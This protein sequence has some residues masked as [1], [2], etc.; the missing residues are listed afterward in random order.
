LTFSCLEIY[1]GVLLF[2]SVI[3]IKR[4]ERV[5][6]FLFF[7]YYLEEPWGCFLSPP[8]DAPRDADMELKLDVFFFLLSFFPPFLLLSGINYASFF[9]FTGRQAEVKP[10][11]R[12][13]LLF[14]SLLFPPGDSGGGWLFFSFP[15]PPYVGEEIRPLLFSFLLPSSISRF[16]L[17]SI[18]SL[19][20]VGEI[21]RL[22]LPLFNGEL[23]GL[24]FFFF[25]LSLKRRKI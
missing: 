3:P 21:T 1:G 20:Q 7:S 9:L 5:S 16:R 14:P 24:P 13:P 19:L 11:A 25:F 4:V 10:L 12:V 23:R 17:R 8:L 6:A 22:P 2:F 18:F 15:F